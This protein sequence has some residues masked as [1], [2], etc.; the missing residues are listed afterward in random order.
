[1]W[2][3]LEFGGPG[4]DDLVVTKHGP[5]RML[6]DEKQSRGHKCVSTVTGSVAQICN[7]MLSDE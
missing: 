3:A 7:D 6:S 2:P 4:V 1:M 5:Q